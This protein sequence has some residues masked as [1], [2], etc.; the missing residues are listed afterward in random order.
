MEKKRILIIDDDPGILV[1]LELLLQDAGYDV[2]TS[3]KNGEFVEAAVMNQP[4][5]LIILD[6]LL[7]GHDGGTIC[8]Q[9]KSQEHT[10]HIPI[11]LISAHPN[12]RVISD[13]AGADG[14]L[15]KPFDVDVLLEQIEHLL[16]RK[17][18]AST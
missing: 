6:I 2:E 12:A 17:G 14:F 16:P 10:H 13:E 9:L 11:I 3:T 8:K 4:P 15:E 7:S 1:P 18:P 5:D